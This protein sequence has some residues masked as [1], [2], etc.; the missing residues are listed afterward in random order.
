MKILYPQ[1]ITITSSNVAGSAYST[2]SS[3]TAYTVGQNVYLSTNYGEYECMVNNTNKLPSDPANSYDATLN[4][5]GSWKFLGTTNKYKMFDQFLNTQTSNATVIECE[6]VAFGAEAL[7]I[8]NLDASSVVIEVINN[9]TLAV[10]ETATVSLYGEVTNWFDYFSGFWISDK[11]DSLIYE[12]T[13]SYKNISFI[14]T[15]N[16]N[17]GVAKCGIFTCGYV[18]EVGQAKYGV[19]LGAI[20]YST[21]IVN[22]TSGATYLEQGNYAKTLNVDIFAQTSALTSL[23]RALT[24]ARGKPVVFIPSNRYEALNIYGYIRS[25]DVLVNGPVETAISCEVMGLI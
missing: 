13:T 6:I 20:D 3:A 16:G 8:G 24:D 21:V 1:E 2:W 12:R 4:P 22:S 19:K 7:Y 23:Y 11:K 9:D 18:R 15:I 17:N 25:F 10:L 5:T 14:I